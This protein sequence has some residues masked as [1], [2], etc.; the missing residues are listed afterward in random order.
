MI[1]FFAFLLIFSSSSDGKTVS[2]DDTIISMKIVQNPLLYANNVTVN[3]TWIFSSGINV[4]NVVIA[5]KNL[6]SSQYAAMGLGQHQSMGEA[7]VFMC[8]RFANDTISIGRFVN[9]QDHH[10]PVPA[11]SEQGGVFTPLPSKFMDGIV[12]CQFNLS[13]FTRK[14]AKISDKLRPLSQSGQYHP[15]FAVGMLNSTGDAQH[16]D[17]RQPQQDFV[18][19]NQNQNLIYHQNSTKPFKKIYSTA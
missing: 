1:F 17:G 13:N 4:T 18:Q 12:T 5:I 2:L 8:K 3:V 10:P 9:P 6:Q 14:T 11:G 19:L 15:L 7:H 16:H